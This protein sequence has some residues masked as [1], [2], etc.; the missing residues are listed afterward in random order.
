[1]SIL[2]KESPNLETQLTGLVM[3][4]FSCEMNYNRGKQ[5]TSS[6]AFIL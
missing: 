5:C 6:S 1:M 4:R 2:C 3:L